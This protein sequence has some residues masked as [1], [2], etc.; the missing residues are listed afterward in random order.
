MFS[1]LLTLQIGSSYGLRCILIII[2]MVDVVATDS[3]GM[4]ISYAIINVNNHNGCSSG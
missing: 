3:L 4:S 2:I 1:Y